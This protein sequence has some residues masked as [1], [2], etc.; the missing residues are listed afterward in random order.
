MDQQTSMVEVQGMIENHFVSILIDLG[1]S[2]SDISPSIVEKCNLSLKIFEKSWLVQL[3]TGTKRKVVNYVES[4]NF[5]MIQF[6]T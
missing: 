1:A 3:A 6:E 5:C 4:C 2:L